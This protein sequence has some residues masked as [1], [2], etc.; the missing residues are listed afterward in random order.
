MIEY[1]DRFNYY[2]CI[3]RPYVLHKNKHANLHIGFDYCNDC[4]R[5]AYL[6]DQYVAK[7]G[8]KIESTKG[9]I[10]YVKKS[11][12]ICGSLLSKKSF[13]GHFHEMS[14]KYLKSFKDFMAAKRE[15]QN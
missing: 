1:E 2:K 6:W 3:D 12:H 5:E 8:F 13:H 11:N 10:W 9:V 4:A 7:V 15:S 14:E